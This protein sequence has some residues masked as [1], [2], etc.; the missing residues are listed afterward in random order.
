VL[1]L[2]RAGGI[3]P[4]VA[5]ALVELDPELAAGLGVQPLGQTLRRLHP[6]TVDEELLGEL[7]LALE[8]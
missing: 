1:V 3:A 4:R 8:L 5:A 7:A 6:E 2:V